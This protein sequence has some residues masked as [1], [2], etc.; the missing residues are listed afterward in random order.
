MG[1]RSPNYH[2]PLAIGARKLGQE[3]GTRGL[4]PRSILIEKIKETRDQRFI[5]FLEVW[6][7]VAFR[8]IQAALEL[9]IGALSN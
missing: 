1:T 5:P 4:A 7:A 9:A 2:H 3:N 6:K 8:K